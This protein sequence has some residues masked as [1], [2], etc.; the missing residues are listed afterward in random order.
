[1]DGPSMPQVYE[2]ESFQLNDTMLWNFNTHPK[3][4]SIALGTN[5]MSRGDKVHPRRPFD[6]TV[7]VK[8]YISFVQL[9]KSKYPKATIALL[10]SPMING[11]DRM[12]LQNCLNT[13]RH[14]IDALYPGDKPVAVFFFKP[15]NAGGCSGHPSVADHAVLAE[16]LLPFFKNLL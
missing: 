5:D 1:M 9:V 8:D 2:K 10:S 3:I 11:G 16:E 13:V 15:M 14:N 6:S 7:F 12:L 4:V